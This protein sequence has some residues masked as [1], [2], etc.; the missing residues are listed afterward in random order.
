MP[1]LDEC[2]DQVVHAL[3]KAGW[4]I[5][6]SPYYFVVAGR[7]FYIDLQVVS[8][9]AGAERH[10][11]IVEIKCFSDEETELN[12]LYTAVGQYAVYR[13]LLR[14]QGIADEVYLAVPA[15]AHQALFQAL[16]HS[17]VDEFGI[18]MVIVD[19][20]REVIEQWLS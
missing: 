2:H 6:H 3:E 14:Q 9:Q 16:A 1:R 5:L 20:E 4:S 7:R 8:S 17:V 10:I 12:E 15:H 11:I 19:L 18:K 13:A